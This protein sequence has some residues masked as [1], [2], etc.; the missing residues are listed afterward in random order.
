MELHSPHF[1]PF[2]G[3]PGAKIDATRRSLQPQMSSLRFLRCQPALM[4]VCSEW[5]VAAR[6]DNHA[7]GQADDQVLL[8]T[9]FVLMRT[10][11]HPMVATERESAPIPG[12][13]SVVPSGSVKTH[14]EA[15]QSRN[16][17]D[18][19]SNRTFF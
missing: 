7:P 10:S 15:G 17:D 12:N 19:F 18:I 2:A 16:F 8:G 13:P 4:V 6:S 5:S 1:S 9:L 14:S 3:S 11:D